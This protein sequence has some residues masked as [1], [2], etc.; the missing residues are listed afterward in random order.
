[1]ATEDQLSEY[2][3]SAIREGRRI[4][5]LKR[6]RNEKGL[7]LK[8]AKVLIDREIALNHAD[9]PHYLVK[10]LKIPL[11]VVIVVVG[12]LTILVCYWV[13]QPDRPENSPTPDGE[14]TSF[15]QP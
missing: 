6:L 15:V 2:V 11:S 14:A 5:A 9:N 10:P 3:V 4:E 1:M 13:T 8:D 12:I 7:G